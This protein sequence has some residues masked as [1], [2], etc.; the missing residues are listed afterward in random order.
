MKE[1]GRCC[2]VRGRI[3][4]RDPNMKLKGEILAKF[5]YY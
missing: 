4:I 1:R 2:D 5:L 3:Q